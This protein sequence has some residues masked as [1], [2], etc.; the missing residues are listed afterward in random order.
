MTPDQIKKAFEKARA[1]QAAGKLDDAAKAYARILKAAPNVAAAQFSLGQILARQGKAAEAERHYQAAVKLRPSEAAIWF[2]YLELISRHP[3]PARLHQ[4]LSQAGKA[5][6][7]TPAAILYPALLAARTG[8]A[9]AEDAL[10]KARA[11]GI[12]DPRLGVA[13]AQIKDR[14]GAPDEALALLDDVLSAHPKN[15]VALARKAEILRDTSRL[16]EALATAR[17]A[18]DA[19]PASG[20]LYHLYAGIRKIQSDDP[21]VGQMQKLLKK[22]PKGHP[23]IPSLAHGLAKA[24]EDTGAKGKVFG[25]LK[26][27]NAESNKRFPYD[28]DADL[29]EIDARQTLYLALKHD[30]ETPKQ[31]TAD[32]PVFVT[33]MPRSGTTLIEQ[34]IAAHSQVTGGGEL[35]LLAGGVSKA[36]AEKGPD[37]EDRLKKAGAVYQDRLAVRFP[38]ATRVTDKSI[39]TYSMIGFVPYILPAARV[40]VVRRDPRDNALSLYKNLFV[41]G[42]HRYANDLRNIARFMRAF[43]DQLAFWRK[44]CPDQFFEIAYED[45]VNAPEDATKALISAVGL[46]WED[47]CLSFHDSDAQVRT[48]SSAQVRQPLYASSIG[49]WQSFEEELAPF[50][51]EYDRL[52]GEGKPSLRQRA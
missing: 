40:V 20:G 46:T 41:G 44:H 25:Y 21:V 34:I 9:G 11:A 48:L 30:G 43:E 45:V 6:V 52:S 47:A 26:I 15:D 14:A 32:G 1:Q 4:V 16:D 3:D 39:S 51:E 12:D 28:L 10:K 17:S 31:Q 19:V 22:K 37:L 2:G 13:L 50:I 27:A 24:M 29:A 5:I 35:G 36:L 49:K 42:R 8:Q 23:D 33:G 18:I 7:G 38:D